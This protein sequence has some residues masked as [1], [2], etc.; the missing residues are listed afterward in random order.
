MVTGENEAIILSNAIKIP[1]YIFDN[2]V[3]PNNRCYHYIN[4]QP[5]QK[6]TEEE[7]KELRFLVSE[8]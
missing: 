6:S 2:L 5:L 7:V 4:N 3:L 1:N 8:K